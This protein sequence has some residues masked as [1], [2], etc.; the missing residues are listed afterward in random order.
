[1]CVPV[2][3]RLPASPGALTLR[4]RFPGM[5]DWDPLSGKEDYVPP[6]L[7]LVPRGGNWV[8]PKNNQTCKQLQQANVFR[9][10]GP[11]DLKVQL[12]FHCPSLFVFPEWGGSLGGDLGSSGVTVF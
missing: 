8:H 1:M 12:F 5:R 2:G 11:N 7:H 9:T 4:A 3:P 6:G 10:R